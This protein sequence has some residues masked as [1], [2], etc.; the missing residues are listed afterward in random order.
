[1]GVFSWAQSSLQKIRHD[2]PKTAGAIE[3]LAG[4]HQFKDPAESLRRRLEILDEQINETN[5]NLLAAQS[6]KVRSYLGNTQGLWAGLQRRRHFSAAEDSAQWHWQHLQE[7]L[8]NRSKAQ[9]ELDRLTGQLWPKRL[10]RWL[11]LFVIA[12]FLIAGIGVFLMG[13]MAAIYMLPFWGSALLIFWLIKT[14]RIGQSW[15]K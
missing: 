14:N 7:L 10:R 4:R 12:M 15:R 2:H 11:A 5:R 9:D 1:M 3:K 13:L 8:K 6:V